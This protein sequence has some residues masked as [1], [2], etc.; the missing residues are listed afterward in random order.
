[1]AEPQVWEVPGPPPA[2]VL[3][4]IDAEGYEWRRRDEAGAVW[5][6]LYGPSTWRSLVVDCGPLRAG[7]LAP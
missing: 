4:V 5:V 1:M 7:E 6:D 2:N 3:T